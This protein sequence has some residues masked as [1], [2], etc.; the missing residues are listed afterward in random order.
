MYTVKMEM[1]WTKLRNK[2]PTNII[3]KAP[4]WIAN[5]ANSGKR[6]SHSCIRYLT[7]IQVRTGRLS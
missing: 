6:K 3:S 2:C 5:C 1:R 4:P 7:M